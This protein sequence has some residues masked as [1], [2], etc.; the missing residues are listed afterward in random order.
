MS[1]FKFESGDVIRNSIVSY[2][3]SKFLFYSGS[4]IYNDY[5]QENGEDWDSNGQDDLTLY[6]EP[7]NISLYELNVDRPSGSDDSNLI[8]PY[9][10]AGSD[11]SVTATTSSVTTE[12]DTYGVYP[13][14]SSI[15]PRYI[16]SSLGEITDGNDDERRMAYSLENTINHY[17]YMSTWFDT[18][19]LYA[20]DFNVISIPSVF[21]GNK[22]NPG[23]VRLELIVTG[24]QDESITLEDKKRNGE[25]VSADNKVHGVVLYSEGFIILKKDE[26]DE[27]L[28]SHPSGLEGDHLPMWKDFGMRTE[29]RTNYAWSIDFEGSSETPVLTMFAHAKKNEV[30]H[31]NNPSFLKVRLPQTSSSPTLYEEENNKEIKN[32]TKTELLEEDPLFKKETYISKIAIYDEQKRIIGYAKLARPIRKTEERELTFKM[33]IDL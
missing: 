18:N 8:R 12:G 30:N 11:W 28:T 10:P 5:V 26:S 32:I 7:G 33:K 4:V 16:N 20:A 3:K 15:F 1:L 31:S 22:I 17:K 21:Y 23:S 6:V 2:P 14:S 13:L 25:L 29:D 24:S 27:Y 19:K 9:I